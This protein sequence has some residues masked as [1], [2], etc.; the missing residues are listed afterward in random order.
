[1]VCAHSNSACDEITIRLTQCLKND[2]LFRVYAKSISKCSI[3]PAISKVCNIVD[4]E[5]RFLSLSYLHQFRV[6]VCTLLTAGTLTRAREMD[7][8]F[9]SNQF[10]HIIIDDAACAHEPMTM[11]AIAGMCTDQNV[12]RS[13]IVLAGDPKQ[14]DAVTMSQYVIRLGFIYSRKLFTSGRQPGNIIHAT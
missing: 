9:K 3:D 6:V 4:D 7:R 13:K 11:V 1:M 2:E 8:S 14:L 12:I 10:S 5:I